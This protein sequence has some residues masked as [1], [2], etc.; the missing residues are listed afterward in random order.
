DSA[1]AI[2]R[3]RE[4]QPFRSKVDGFLALS[5]HRSAVAGGDFKLHRNNVREHKLLCNFTVG[6]LRC[7]RIP[8]HSRY[9][10]GLTAES[11]FNK[12]LL[13]RIHHG[14]ERDRNEK[15]PGVTLQVPTAFLL[16]RQVPIWCSSIILPN[17]SSMKICSRCGP[18]T[19]ANVQYL[20]P[21][22]SSSRLASCTFGTASATW[23]RVGS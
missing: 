10:F 22:R 14:E 8:P 7:S 13:P 20:T 3:K 19:P 1:V 4:A 17:G 21:S 16:Q 9:F 11:R 6:R 5:R 2:D 15:G 23:V 12:L 18:T